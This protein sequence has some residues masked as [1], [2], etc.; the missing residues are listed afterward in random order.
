MY[1]LK[2]D[3]ITAI[4]PDSWRVWESVALDNDTYTDSEWRGCD[5]RVSS[6]NASGLAV[7]IY[8][9]GRNSK[10]DFG[11]YKTRARIV[12]PKDGGEDPIITKGIVYSTEPL[13]KPDE[14]G[15]S[16]FIKRLTARLNRIEK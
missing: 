10:H 4:W 6:G 3:K 2:T 8:I 11:M 16:E 13:T 15:E 1:K 12:F 9:T 7:D 5:Y 14:A